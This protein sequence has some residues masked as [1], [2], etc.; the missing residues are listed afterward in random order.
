VVVYKRGS[1]NKEQWL[2]PF[3]KNLSSGAYIVWE[4]LS[5]AYKTLNQLTEVVL[6]TNLLAQQHR[7]IMCARFLVVTVAWMVYQFSGLRGCI[8]EHFIPKF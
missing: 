3:C 1:D 6:K 5:Q 2:H 4:E 8:T 7:E